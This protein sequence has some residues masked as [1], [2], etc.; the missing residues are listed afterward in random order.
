MI[1]WSVFFLHLH[2]Y[3][4]SFQLIIVKLLQT[5]FDLHLLLL[6]HNHSKNTK[7]YQ[8]NIYLKRKNILYN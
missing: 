4:S 6:K 1:F 8:R 7:I 2:E 3:A 5:H